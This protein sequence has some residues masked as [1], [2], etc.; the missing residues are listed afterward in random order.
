MR[1]SPPLICLLTLAGCLAPP[2]AP[3]DRWSELAAR[4]S[5]APPQTAA[6]VGGLEASGEALAADVASGGSLLVP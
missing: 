5:D 6:P 2:P 3:A 4:V 1:F